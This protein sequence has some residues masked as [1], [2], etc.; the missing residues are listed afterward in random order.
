MRL[1]FDFQ[2]LFSRVSLPKHP[3]EELSDQEP[4]K[5]GAIDLAARDSEVCKRGWREGGSHKQGQNSQKNSLPEVFPLL[6]Y[7]LAWRDRK[8]EKKKGC[9]ILWHEKEFLAPTPSVRQPLVIP[10]HIMR[11]GQG[12]LHEQACQGKRIMCDKR[13]HRDGV[14]QRAHTCY[15]FSPSQCLDGRFV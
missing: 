7:F 2:V 8:Q 11:E 13:F 12:I 4:H 5:A 3:R 15:N 9:L 1:R 6:G 14:G 10:S